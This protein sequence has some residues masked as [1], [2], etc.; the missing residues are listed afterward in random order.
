MIVTSSSEGRARTE[1]QWGRPAG[2][3]KTK[4]S[5][6]SSPEIEGEKSKGETDKGNEGDGDC[7]EKVIVKVLE[8]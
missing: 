4:I 2:T 1:Y 7:R 8:S 5:E 3:T 6:F